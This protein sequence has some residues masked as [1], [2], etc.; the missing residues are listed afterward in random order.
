MRTCHKNNN[1]TTFHRFSDN[2]KLV[3][4]KIN[5]QNFSF[6]IIVNEQSEFDPK[7]EA[8]SWAVVAH[9]FN[10]ST[11]E[12]GA[13]RT[14]EFKAKLAVLELPLGYPKKPCVKKG[15]RGRAQD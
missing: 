8:G 5:T 13:A 1:K 11:S 2:I 12:T 14:L 10:P 9:V 15:S 4:H 7:I 3:R 6:I